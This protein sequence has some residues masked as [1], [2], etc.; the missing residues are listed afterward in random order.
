MIVNC[1][2]LKYDAGIRKDVLWNSFALLPDSGNWHTVLLAS[3]EFRLLAQQAEYE[4]KYTKQAHS[5]HVYGIY[6]YLRKHHNSM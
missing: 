1:R 5:Y 4:G 3:A 6:Q 2:A